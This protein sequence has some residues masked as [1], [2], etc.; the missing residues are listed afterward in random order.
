MA[1]ED[2]WIKDQIKVTE[3][4]GFDNARNTEILTELLKKINKL[5]QEVKELRNGGKKLK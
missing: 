3:I 4:S 2:D 1:Y 5:E